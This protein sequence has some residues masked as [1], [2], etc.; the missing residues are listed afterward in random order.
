VANE[1]QSKKIE[2]SFGA[3]NS[4]ANVSQQ[5]RRFEAMIEEKSLPKEITKWLQKSGIFA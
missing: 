4:A 1:F 2:P 3:R 5:L